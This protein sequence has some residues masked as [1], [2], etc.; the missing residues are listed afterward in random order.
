MQVNALEALS[1]TPTA[2]ASGL[3]RGL[4]LKEA[5][6]ANVVEMVGVGPFITIPFLISAM[7]GPQALVAWLFGAVLAVCDGL[8]WAELGAA[9]PGA[10]GSYIYLREAYGPNRMGHLMGFLFV[11]MILFTAPLSAATGS[12]GFAEYSRYLFPSLSRSATPWIAVAVM[13]AVT[14]AAYRDIKGVGRLSFWLMLTVLGSIL[15]IIISGVARFKFALLTDFPPHA[16]TLS[17]PFFWG[18]GQG[19][20]LAIYGY[21]GYNNVCFL[22][23][24]VKEPA[25]NIPRSIIASILLVA[26]LYFFMTVSIVGV[27]PWREAAKSPHIVADFMQLIYG[28]WA[29][30]LVT[31]MILGASFASVFALVLGLS[32][33]PYAAAV[34]RQFFPVFGRLHST[35]RFPHVAVA[36]LGLV[37]TLFCFFNLESIIQVLI[38]VQVII[39][40][41]AQVVAV[42]LIRKRPDVHRPFQMWL[43]PLPSIAAMTLWIFVLISTGWRIVAV[44]LAVLAAGVVLY[45]FRARTLRLWPFSKLSIDC[46][47]TRAG[48][49]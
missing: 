5:T 10:G 43:Y 19:T 42:T 8:V 7:G 24:E 15:W 32:R 12:V 35:G 49:A 36:T 3:V 26:T 20:L 25:R 16:F 40:F 23:G 29:G 31:V 14:V 38:V 18:L 30:K 4:G 27:M 28:T 21:G 37:S 2:K 41:L 11:W 6:A 48:Q 22:G 39:L 44:A 45:L 1:E 33:I 17:K 9:M 34:N 47:S 46:A 13:V